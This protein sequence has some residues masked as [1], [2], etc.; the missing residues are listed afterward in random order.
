MMRI[1]QKIKNDLLNLIKCNLIVKKYLTTIIRGSRMKKVHLCVCIALWIVLAI[2]I[3]LLSIVH[4][5]LVDNPYQFFWDIVGP[6]NVVVAWLYVL[7]I[8]PIIFIITLI[9]ELLKYGER[10]FITLILPFIVTNVM[11]IVYGFIHILW[12]GGV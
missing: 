7:S 4:F 5:E 10:L 8:E 2:G 11:W 12:T 6:Y 3:F 1:N 9:R